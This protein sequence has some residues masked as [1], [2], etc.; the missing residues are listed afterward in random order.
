MIVVQMI[1]KLIFQSNSVFNFIK[2]K[3]AGGSFWQK[4][5]NKKNLYP[6]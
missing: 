1:F 3:I 6:G 5:K 4:V 2:C